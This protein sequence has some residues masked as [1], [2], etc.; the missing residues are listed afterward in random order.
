MLG[1]LHVDLLF[2][3]CDGASSEDG[4]YTTDLHVASNEQAMMRIAD[5]VVVVTESEKF[6]KRAFSRYARPEDISLVVTD[7][8][9]PERDLRNLQERGVTVTIAE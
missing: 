4:F 7:A 9:L 6:G 1:T 8:A 2:I 3:G 5:R